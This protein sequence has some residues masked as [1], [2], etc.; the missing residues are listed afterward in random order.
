[1]Q[2]YYLWVVL[3]VTMLLPPSFKTGLHHKDEH[4][5]HRAVEKIGFSP[6]RYIQVG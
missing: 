4:D 3:P 2:F 5:S 1:M 6:S